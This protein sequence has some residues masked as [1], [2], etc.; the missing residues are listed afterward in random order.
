MSTTSAIAAA[1]RAA[2]LN[3]PP[4]SPVQLHAASLLAA[5]VRQAAAESQKAAGKPAA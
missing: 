2:G 3:S 5:P 4:P 1:G